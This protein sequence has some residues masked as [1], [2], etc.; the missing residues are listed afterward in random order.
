MAKR[1][2]RAAK[3]YRNT[4]NYA[5]PTWV[6]IENVADVN[7]SPLAKDKIDLTRRASGGWK[8]YLSAQKD[9]EVTGDLIQDLADA[10]Y[11]AIRDSFLNDTALEYL[12]LSGPVN[13]AGEEGIRFTGEVI[14]FDRSEAVADAQK[15][16][17][18][19]CPSAQAAN[20]PAWYTAI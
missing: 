5:S 17:I 6:E 14:K 10:D 13:T 1:L 19:I 18:A 15:H 11:T 2:G 8:E 16:A 7:V 20:P 12:V 4:G 3:F 9:F